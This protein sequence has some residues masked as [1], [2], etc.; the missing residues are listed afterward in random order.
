MIG[1]FIFMHV[2]QQ[3]EIPLTNPTPLPFM[4]VTALQHQATLAIA[5]QDYPR[6]IALL[7]QCI[8]AQPEVRS[9]YW[10]L[11]LVYC[12]VDEPL[13]AQWVWTAALAESEADA[14]AA[15]TA[16]LIAFL[17]RVALSY[18]QARQTH[19]AE[20]LYSQ[21]LELDADH[22]AAHYNLGTLLVNLNQLAAAVEHLRAAIA[23]QPD[24][25]DAHHNLG[26]ALEKLGDQD[27]AIASYTQALALQ[28]QLGD[29]HYRLGL[30]Y[31]Q[32]GQPE[33]AIA[34]FHQAIQQQPNQPMANALAHDAIA[35]LCLAQ[36][37]WA[38]AIA[39]LGH[40]VQCQPQFAAAYV[41][42]YGQEDGQAAQ[43]GD[44]C[45]TAKLRC[46]QHWMAD[47]GIADVQTNPS[48]SNLVD[49]AQLVAERIVAKL[50]QQT[51]DAGDRIQQ[52]MDTAIALLQATLAHPPA[53]ASLSTLLTQLLT[54]Q[55]QLRSPTATASAIAADAIAADAI[56]APTQ[57]YLSTPAW[58]TER[59]AQWSASPDTHYRAIGTEEMIDLPPS[60]NP[61]G[62]FA[63]RFSSPAPGVAIIPQGRIYY[64]ALATAIVS[65]D[66]F[67]LADL[68][69]YSPFPDPQRP[70]PSYPSRHPIFS[71]PTLPTAQRFE[72][73]LIGLS[74]LLTANYFHWMTELLPSLY[75]LQQAGIDLTAYSVAIHCYQGLSFQ[76]ETLQAMGIQPHQVISSLTTDHLQSASL[77][78]PSLPGYIAWPP[79]WVCE[80]LQA[81]LLTQP[82]AAA[83]SAL[84]QPATKRLYI[85]RQDAKIRRVLNEGAVLDVLRPLGFEAVTLNGKTVAEQAALFHSAAVIVAPHGAGLTNLAFC[86][87]GTQVLEL[88][89]SS[90][91]QWPTYWAIA[92]QAQ[93]QYHSLICSGTGG[94]LLR[95][96]LYPNPN[97]EDI[98][99][100]LQQLRYTLAAM[101]ITA[102]PV[103]RG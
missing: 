35:A 97:T 10:Q 66:N 73:P 51:H 72:Q 6:A 28:P 94:S 53:P 80:F 5:Q 46:L 34:H 71:Q 77:I 23:L 18:L 20:Q 2:P 55:T 78:V 65:P 74:S 58:L 86:T 96:L 98:W 11:G 99:V 89:A 102:P 37:D 9:H 49:L 67:L 27:G 33:A 44:A 59:G 15:G 101:G 38:G 25:A 61:D 12:L 79:R 93:L 95:T 56:P 4:D 60:R 36:R 8:T 31:Q 43:P 21:I 69:T 62:F 14:V 57:L 29:T 30:C 24:L 17:D 7:G 45:Q 103:V 22:L 40:V 39:A 63:T 76:V 87:P 82:N 3:H 32:Q 88:F 41:A 85:S 91:E 81:M 47:E 54:Y 84:A 16:E 83:P 50:T 64:Q 48:Q 26:Y 19:V 13:E 42:Y 1:D 92:G 68:S 70:D 90:E 100:D 75:L 52:D